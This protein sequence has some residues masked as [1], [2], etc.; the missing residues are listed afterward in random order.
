M[1]SLGLFAIGVIYPIWFESEDEKPFDE[2]Q[3]LQTVMK[4][5]GSDN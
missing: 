5:I 4:V 1:A 3:T 2:T